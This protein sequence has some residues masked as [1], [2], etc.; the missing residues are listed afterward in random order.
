[1][2]SSPQTPIKADGGKVGGGREEVVSRET[3]TYQASQRSV[4]VIAIQD[5]RGMRK[6]GAQKRK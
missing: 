2:H 5:Q 4:I 6:W 1:M 3:L